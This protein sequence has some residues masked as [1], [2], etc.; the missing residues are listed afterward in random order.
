MKVAIY[1]RVSTPG[2]ELEHQVEACRKLAEAKD[3]DVIEVYQ[4]IGS[5]ANFTRPAFKQLLELLRGRYFD[6]V[7]TF[8]LDRLGRKAG[9]LALLLEELENRGIRIFTVYDNWDT[10]TPIGRAMRA[11]AVAF[12][13][14]EREQIS[15]QTK[16]RL[17]SL[18]A[19]GKKLGR[20]PISDY[21]I[22]RVLDLLNM[23]YTYRE[24][25]AEV[26]VSVGTITKIN[27]IRQEAFN[28]E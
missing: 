12:A 10:G 25:K 1:A 18:K 21:K 15:E 23:D 26:K 9:Q 24:I 17:E 2:Q 3:L 27:K 16:Q 4:D 11:V 28:A 8:K 20:K 14:L 19:S 5:G 13:E 6:G 22:R 7:I